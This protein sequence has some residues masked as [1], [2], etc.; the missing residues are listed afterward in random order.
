M[1][2]GK[3]AQ[4]YWKETQRILDEIYHSQQDAIEQAADLISN[5]LIEGGQLHL[6][7]TGHTIGNEAVN[8][9]GGLMAMTPLQF[10]LKIINTIAYSPIIPKEPK[11]TEDQIRGFVGYT[12]A[13]SNLKKGDALII[14]SVTGARTIAVEVAL[15]A[16]ELGVKIVGITSMNY[17]QWVNVKHSSGKKLYD[18]S[19]V[20][21][22]NI[23]EIGDA[24]VQVEEMNG[25]ICPT[26]GITAGMIIWLMCAEIVEKMLQKNKKPDVFLSMNLPGATERNQ[27]VVQEIMKEEPN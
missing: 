26:T 14:G 3:L 23:C 19:D 25:K 4:E 13:N 10:D 20:V 22:D 8:R 17:S 6:W 9:A 18:L 11:L 12:L 24:I 7:D 15:Q 16:K 2:L 1:M 27:K 21:I 5:T